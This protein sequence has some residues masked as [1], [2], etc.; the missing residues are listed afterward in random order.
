MVDDHCVAAFNVPWVVYQCYII[1]VK[2]NFNSTYTINT[3]NTSLCYFILLKE[4]AEFL[5]PSLLKQHPEML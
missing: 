3:I 2:V 4:A 1:G 5:H